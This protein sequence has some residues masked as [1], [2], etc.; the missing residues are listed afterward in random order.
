MLDTARADSII[1]SARAMAVAPRRSARER[2]VAFRI[3]LTLVASVWPMSSP[4]DPTG[5][6]APMAVSGAIAA[7]CP[8]RVMIVPALPAMAPRGET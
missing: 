6:A 3:S 4:C 8:A 1:S 5:L 2:T 7:A